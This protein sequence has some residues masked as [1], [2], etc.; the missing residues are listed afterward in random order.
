MHDLGQR[1]TEERL[2]RTIVEG[3]AAL[4]G[5]EFFRAL[6]KNLAQAL[7]A[8]YCFA[9]EFTDVKTRVRILAHWTRAVSSTTSSSTSPVRR[10]RRC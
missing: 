2:L 8:D 10:A 7:E 6:V 9:A 3:T 1:Q 4:T 5:E